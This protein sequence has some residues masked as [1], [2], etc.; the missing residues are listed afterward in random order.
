MLLIATLSTFVFEINH[1]DVANKTNSFSTT[2]KKDQS[3]LIKELKNGLDSTSKFEYIKISNDS[4]ISWTN[5]ILLI[6]EFINQPSGLLK[7]SG[8]W[9]LK[10]EDTKNGITTIGI[11]PVKRIFEN[12]NSYLQTHFLPQYKL[13]KYTKIKNGKNKGGNEF[14]IEGQ[15]YHLEFV[16]SLSK[17]S[18][19][20]AFI[21]AL[22]LCLLFYVAIKYALKINC[23]KS[24]TAL[25]VFSLLARWVL[26]VSQFPYHLSLNSLFQPN[27][28]ASTQFLPSLGDLFIHL[29]TFIIIGIALVKICT[30]EGSTIIKRVL[31]WLYNCLGF[32]GLIHV[33]QTLVRDGNVNLDL[34][35]LIDLE[36]ISLIAVVWLLLSFFT[37]MYFL[38]KGIKNNKAKNHKDFIIAIILTTPLFYFLSSYAILAYCSILIYYA[39]SYYIAIK[40]NKKWNFPLITIVLLIYTVST[41]SL[42]QIEIKTKENFRLKEDL[43]SELEDRDPVV[44]FLMGDM[45]T[46]L[47]KDTLLIKSVS[48]H[49]EINDLQQYL[50]S[51]YVSKLPAEFDFSVKKCKVQSSSEHCFPEISTSTIIYQNKGAS[52]FYDIIS[53]KNN[54]IG[55]LNFSNRTWYLFF[56]TKEKNLNYGFPVVLLNKKLEEHYISSQKSYAKYNESIL[57]SKKGNFIYPYLLKPSWKS[58][59]NN[60]ITQVQEEEYRHYIYAKSGNYYVL[61]IPNKSITSY[62]AGYSYFFILG[63]LLVLIFYLV[64]NKFKGV[65]GQKTSL[66]IRFQ[67]AMLVILLFSTI[68]IVIGSIYFQNTQYRK[69]SMDAIADKI[70][71]VQVNINNKL[72]VSNSLKDFNETYLNQ[73]LT[74]ISGIY[75]TDINLYYLDGRLAASSQQRI[76]ERNLMSRYINPQ[77]YRAINNNKKSQFVHMEQIGSLSYLS[78]YVPF[79]NEQNKVIGYINL[80]YFPKT[81]QFDD[82]LNGVLLAL[83][84]IYVLLILLSLFVGFIVFSQITKPLEIIKNSMSELRIGE[85]NK[86]LNWNSNDEIG[87]LVKRYNFMVESLET[88]VHKLAKQERESA[89][90]EMAKQVA[91]EIKNPL[92]PMKLNIQHFQMVW[93]RMTEEERKVKFKSMSENLIE[94][95]ES[96]STIASEFSSFAKMPEGE[97]V[98]LD[99]ISVFSKVFELYAENQAIDWEI[100][101]EVKS[102]K[103]L[104]NKEQMMRVFTNLFQNAVQAISNDRKGKITASVVVDDQGLVFSI[105]DNGTGIP[106]EIQSKIFTPNFTTKSSG[107]GLGLAMVQQIVQLH[108]AEIWFKTSNEGTNFSLRFPKSKLL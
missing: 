104:A 3:E 14:E 26:L 65:K 59:L 25:I 89:W 85:K 103:V 44:E 63:I 23:Y 19:G 29:L 93:D 69:N 47:M 33:T 61:T 70:S 84:N 24:A 6:D 101:L 21:E 106:D 96:L 108:D 49:Q 54:Y 77:A 86:T 1:D 71:S 10:Y 32:I 39:L 52:L 13:D 100:N 31:Y 76:F 102:V 48:K 67:T 95:I 87:E 73:L 60:D 83:V 90:R 58:I 68:V 53:E 45:L 57:E 16:D 66:K 78:A 79:I 105:T 12:E 107:S 88:S 15:Q 94:Q 74:V 75:S 91:H 55:V 56:K 64:Y 9:Y 43:I 34:S 20:W 18:S 51:N 99:I 28:Y 46:S 37:L 72:G 30:Q 80:P 41:V 22:G 50:Q 7:T 97:M 11:A 42:L 40:T 27:L 82:E 4:V 62:F 98:E 2:L 35:N 36:L 17:S 38:N 92:T 81:N 8:G 5:N